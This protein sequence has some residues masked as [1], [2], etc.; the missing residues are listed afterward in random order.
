[1][2]YEHRCPPT[3]TLAPE[4]SAQVPTRRKAQPVPLR[5]PVAAGKR[6]RVDCWTAW[7]G[8]TP[9]ARPFCRIALVS[10]RS[11]RPSCSG[12]FV[13][14]ARIARTAGVVCHGCAG[15]PRHGR[16][17][18]GSGW[19]I[20]RDSRRPPPTACRSRRD[21]PRR[22]TASPRTALPTSPRRRLSDLGCGRSTSCLPVA[23][24]PA[25][26]VG[27][28]EAARTGRSGG[29]LAV[30]VRSSC[31][32]TVRRAPPRQSTRPCASS[33]ARRSLL[34]AATARTA[35]T[36]GSPWGSTFAIVRATST[37]GRRAG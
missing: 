16:W 1:L 21:L 11:F 2:E 26:P 32:S 22:A 37:L 9:L 19:T 17:A 18:P 34:R 35:E 6:A 14:E 33:S 3:T 24:S 15:A 13:K 20:L 7:I 30:P 8:N 25:A 27:S 12:P 23:G 31:T 5:A 10:R 29:R 4:C 28:R 36:M